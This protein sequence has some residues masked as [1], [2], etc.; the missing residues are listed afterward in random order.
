MHDAFEF[1][2]ALANPHSVAAALLFVLPGFVAFKIDQRL[3]PQAVRSGFDAI[4]EII[5]YSIVNDLLWSPLYPF[6]K[7]GGFPTSIGSWLFSLLVLVCSPAILTWV[8]AVS[9]DALAARGVLPSPT[10]KPWD[11]FFQ[12][13][14]NKQAGREVGVIL[15]LR[16]GRRLGGVYKAPGFASSFPAEE[17]LLLGETWLLDKEGGFQERVFGSPGLLIDKDDILALEF[18][19]RQTLPRGTNGEQ[20]G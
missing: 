6:G 9:I 11:H 16:D 15:T 2:Q 17:Q 8:F 5:V 20:H 10:P 19:A 3:R 7:Q 13:V 1:F 18:F 4:L 14:V 12:R